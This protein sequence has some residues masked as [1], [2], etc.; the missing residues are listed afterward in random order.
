MRVQSPLGE[1]NPLD[2]PA[3]VAVWCR[4][5]SK[6]LTKKA[7]DSEGLMTVEA[8]KDFDG[9]VLEAGWRLEGMVALDQCLS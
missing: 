2:L 3:A 1:S 8:R 7:K 4:P 6:A 9:G 5:L